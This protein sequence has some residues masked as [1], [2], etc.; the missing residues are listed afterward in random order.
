MN[1]TER[2]PNYVKFND[3]DIYETVCGE[4]KIDERVNQLLPLQDVLKVEKIKI[5]GA[6]FI[7]FQDIK[8]LQNLKALHLQRCDSI[9]IKCLSELDNLRELKIT[10]GQIS[11]T[12][13]F[14]LLTQLRTLDLSLNNVSDLSPLASLNQL[15]SLYLDYNLIVDVSPLCNL[16]NLKVLT[17]DSNIML[18]NINPLARMTNLEFLSLID[19]NRNKSMKISDLR[20]ALQE[21]GI[22]CKVIGSR[23]NSNIRLLYNYS[24]NI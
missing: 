6:K 22:K 8:L 12:N 7:C 11:L 4:L 13:E 9:D 14:G 16:S 20:E 19:I 15:E 2:Y 3:I 24:W 5:C 1:L 17:L 10:E 23:S 18:R 21:N